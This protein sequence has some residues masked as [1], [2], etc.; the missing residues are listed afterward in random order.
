MKNKVYLKRLFIIISLFLFLSSFLFYFIHRYEYDIYKKNYN[1]KIS[2]IVYLVKEKYPSINEGDI[3]SIVNGSNLNY[4]FSKYGIDIDDSII[5]EN[6]YNYKKFIIID[7]SFILCVCFMVI[8]FFLLYNKKKSSELNNIINLIEQI[9]MKNYSLNIDDI[10]EDELSI[11][12]NEIYKVTVMLK[13][14]SEYSRLEKLKLKDSLADISHQLKTPLTSILI[15]VDNLIDDCTD[16]VKLDFLRDIKRD[17]LNI[18]FLIQNLLKLSKL[19]TNTV[20]FEDADTS[21]RKIVLKAK[22]NLSALCDLR[23]ISIDIAGDASCV[24]DFNWQVEAISNILKNCIEH[25]YD[26]TSIKVDISS[27]KVYCCIKITDNG[28]GITSEDLPHIFERFYKGKN[29][30]ND[31]VGIG[32]ALAKSIIEKDNGHISVS[33]KDSTIFTIKYYF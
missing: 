3:L 20:T 17:A 10:S 27:N 15:M 25:S 7:L 16:Q 5:L 13:E 18:N 24:L 2:K 11:L 9:N 30:T 21:L 4:D 31:S 29:S 28:E 1:D 8:L 6:D 12:K 33:S 14:E 19:D 23:D 32:L 22:S 26:S